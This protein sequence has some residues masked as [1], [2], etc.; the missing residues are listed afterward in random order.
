MNPGGLKK[1][2]MGKPVF[3]SGVKQD[4]RLNVGPNDITSNI[5]VNPNELAL[6]RR[7]FLVIIILIEIAPSL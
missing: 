6:Q 5:K 1:N 2:T 7:E 4:T 3:Y